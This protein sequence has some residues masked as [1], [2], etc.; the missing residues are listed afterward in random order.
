MKPELAS[1]EQSG[2]TCPLNCG[3][4]AQFGQS[5]AAQ[6]QGQGNAAQTAGGARNSSDPGRVCCGPVRERSPDPGQAAVR[7]GRRRN[8]RMGREPP[9]PRHRD[10]RARNIQ[11]PGQA[12]N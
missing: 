9:P 12:A 1:T 11:E 2:A 8:L 7:S 4:P 5:E 6:G 3:G 10:E